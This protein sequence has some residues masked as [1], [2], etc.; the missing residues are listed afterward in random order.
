MDIKQVL[1]GLFI[2]KDGNYQFKDINLTL[3]EEQ[4][5]TLIKKVDHDLISENV[6]KSNFVKAI[7]A[8]YDR[9]RDLQIAFNRR[10]IERLFSHLYGLGFKSNYHQVMHDDHEADC[11]IFTI[12]FR[13]FEQPT[14][15][16]L[17]L[18][19]PTF[20]LIEKPKYEVQ[21]L[22]DIN[23]SLISTD[24]FNNS[25]LNVVIN[26]AMYPPVFKQLPTGELLADVSKKPRD[27]LEM[28]VHGTVQYSKDMFLKNI[29]DTDISPD[30][31]FRG[32]TIRR[33]NK[34]F[35]NALDEGTM[36]D[37]YVIGYD[38]K[39]DR[40]ILGIKRNENSK[41]RTLIINRS[42]YQKL[43][44]WSYHQDNIIDF[45]GNTLKK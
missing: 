5:V 42:V 26:W 15:F 1:D 33:I 28:Y 27:F 9:N 31:Y 45:R 10:D 13:E 12:Y 37:L 22:N 14:E 24:A 3:S 34:Y 16:D 36:K 19:K 4:I 17:T 2:Q 25:L 29:I 38:C 40:L 6:T 11:R 30:I 44:Y 8:F 20:I 18:F 23:I 32:V 7:E 43:Q 21:D 35:D 41:L 39:Y